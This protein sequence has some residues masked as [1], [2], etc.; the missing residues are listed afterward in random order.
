[1]PESA[2]VLNCF[3]MPDN[4]NNSG[5]EQAIHHGPGPM[6]VIAGPGSGKTYTVMQ[7]LLYLIEQK[8]V[9][10]D[11]ILVITFTK[12]A[13]SEM[14]KRFHKL[15]QGKNYPVSFGTFHAVFYHILKT[16]YHYHSG[17]IL[18]EAE[19]REILRIVFDQLKYQY[20]DNEDIDEF[21][22]QISRY[23]NDDNSKPFE[24]LNIEKRNFDIIYRSY[25]AETERRKKLDFDDMVL[26][27]RKLFQNDPHI[28]KIWQNKFKYI[29][30]DE[31]QDINRMQY[32]VVRM[33]A[34]PEN[35]LFAVGDDDQSIY[36]F[37]GASP[38]IMTGFLNDY[39]ES[40]R[41]TLSVNYRSKKEI[42]EASDRLIHKNNYRLEKRME[43]G[44]GNGGAVSFM[45]FKDEEI[46]GNEIAK[47]A[48]G[49][50]AQGK[51]VAVILRTN[52]EAGAFAEYLHD[53]NV[54]YVMREKLKSPFSHNVCQDLM[55]YLSF[56]FGGQKR[57]DFYRIMNR[58]SRYISGKFLDGEMIDI[59]SL[60]E[61]YRD[62]PYMK[63]ILRKLEL[64]L[65]RIRKMDLFAAV[66]YIRKGMG[67][68]EWL[69]QNEKDGIEVAEWFQRKMKSFHDL[70]EFREYVENY[71]NVLK[72][73][74]NEIRENA[75]HLL[76]MHASKGLEFDSVYIPYCNE[77]KIPHKKSIQK[78]QIE[79]ERRM[80]YVAM[81]RAKEKLTISWISG[82]KEEPGLLS[83][84]LSD[85]EVEQSYSPSISSSNSQLSRYSSNA[86][87]TASYSSSS[88]I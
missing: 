85:L 56:V 37:R 25:C 61:A 57:K 38:D 77:G 50:L 41:V 73:K 52:Q 63:P 46:Q 16:T 3:R 48:F 28:L 68:D 80:F 49:D 79:E 15:T 55:A 59:K 33:L 4:H 87:A 76:T 27:C 9:E 65:S 35:N 54:A 36:S 67:Y 53:S 17:N 20:L 31:F 86:S 70:D 40:T 44:K 18:S 22:L 66:N 1:M 29:L 30:I 64:D 26:K 81:T 74:Q 13:A 78:T 11:S 82:T 45:G 58:P 10:P 43:S 71:E 75:V 51:T 5:Q 34:F 42:V 69:K 21:L 88:S 83:R 7:R 72:D 47:A 14:K 2:K 6:L 23:K 12:E 32:D 39:P 60:R 62:V 8:R 84:F 19:K 24:K